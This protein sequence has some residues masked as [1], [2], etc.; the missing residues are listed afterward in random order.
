MKKLISLSIVTILAMGL[1]ACESRTDRTDS[2]GV[3]LSVS[4][5]DGLPLRVGVNAAGAILQVD[6]FTIE[7]IAKDPTGVVSSLMNVELGSYEVTY[8]RA[9][10]GT[11][12]PPPY[13]KG[14]F[15]VVPVNGTAT[16]ENL[17]VM[18]A[19]QFLNQPLSDLDFANG[20]FDKE[21]GSRVVR[22]NLSIRFFGRTLSGD[23]VQTA[24]SQFTVEF[25]P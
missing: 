4:D 11:R 17:D 24:P 7:N 19:D 3:L 14:L 22:L 12:V 13:V 20:G 21:T 5:F 15:G 9:D 25:I 8:T 2:G 18:G 23:A 1:A 16:F 10:T 6:E